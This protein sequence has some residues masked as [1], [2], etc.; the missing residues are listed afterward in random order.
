MHAFLTILP[1]V[2]VMAAGWV[3]GRL[4]VV[5]PE[6]F[7]QINKAIYWTAIPA[8]ILKMTSG[9]NVA[10]MVEKNMVF[11]VYA[12]FMVAPPIAWAAARLAREGRKTAATSTL[13]IIRSNTVFVGL[14][15][16]TVAV[17]EPGV[18]ILSIYLAFTF[19]GYQIISVSWGQLALSGGISRDTVRDT[20][21][22]LA[23]NPLVISS[24]AGFTLALTGLNH[25]PV[26]MDET[27]KLLGNVASGMALLSLGASLRPEGLVAMLPRA[28]RDVALKLLFLPALTWGAF[29][30]FPVSPLVFR[31]VVLIA[32]MPV[33]V[34]CFI[35]SQALG[36][37]SD[38]SGAAITASTLLAGLSIPLWITLLDAFL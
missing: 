35:L 22:N 13:M 23:K 25:F 28:W 5:G 30:I 6:A 3:L 1:V 11:A 19:I 12:T 16:L 36:M 38:H 18:E 26:W 17:G 20:L 21:K 10:A 32:A 8:L 7:A 31:T 24:L 2:L 34:D 33:A 27:L 14:P 15:V 29:L 37:D 4:K 9:G